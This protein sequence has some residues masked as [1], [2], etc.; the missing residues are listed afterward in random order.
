MIQRPSED[1][2][3]HGWMS[4][5]EM[6]VW[7][8]DKNASFVAVLNPMGRDRLMCRGIGEP[9]SLVRRD[10]TSRS[11]SYWDPYR[12]W[13]RNEST[14]DVRSL[15]SAGFGYPVIVRVRF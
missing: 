4:V 8:E 10:W 2:G 9:R 6:A 1:G 3:A 12:E 5:S 11:P 14:S 13:L 15:C 7:R